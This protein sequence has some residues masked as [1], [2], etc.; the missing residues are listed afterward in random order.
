MTLEQI[1][2][3]FVLKNFDLA[4]KKNGLRLEDH[5]IRAALVKYL[6][7]R[8]DIVIFKVKPRKGEG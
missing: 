1:L 8:W 7:D 4:F 2:Y 5:E 6:E 3:G